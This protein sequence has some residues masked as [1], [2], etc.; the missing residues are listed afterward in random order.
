RTAGVR[1]P[2]SVPGED[3]QQDPAGDEQGIDR[4]PRQPGP[5]REWRA[6]GPR[7]DVRPRLAKPQSRWGVP[8][9]PPS[10]AHDLP[11]TW[12]CTAGPAAGA[13]HTY[14]TRV[15]NPIRAPRLPTAHTTVPSEAARWSQLSNRSPRTFG[16][17]IT[18]K[19]V[20]FHRSARVL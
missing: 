10:V 12:E 13:Q 20:P 15:C 1:A 18:W 4:S 3:D 8:P 11:L 2:A 17:D 5:G 14:S 16:V 9:V 7:T 6:L 19:D